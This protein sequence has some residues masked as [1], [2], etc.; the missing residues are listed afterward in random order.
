[1][2][3]SGSGSET[4]EKKTAL[5]SMDIDDTFIASARLEPEVLWIAGEA[6]KFIWLA[7]YDLFVLYGAKNNIEFH[8]AFITHRKFFDPVI[9]AA[10]DTFKNFLDLNHGHSHGIDEADR[11]KY[12]V[13]VQAKPG[14]LEY[15]RQWLDGE[16]KNRNYWVTKNLDGIHS[17]S[18]ADL[19]SNVIIF[20][21]YPEYPEY[22]GFKSKA[23]AILSIADR[24]EIAVKNC[25]HI[26]DSSYILEHIQR[27]GMQAISAE[28]FF[29][30]SDDLAIKTPIAVKR[31]EDKKRKY[32]QA[33]QEIQWKL[34]K[35]LEI[36]IVDPV[37]KTAV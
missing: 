13:S 22:K 27:S 28:C 16:G 33:I 15:P 34:V 6:G 31:A 25:H 1:M 37:F 3:G 24:Y 20:R 36:N 35:S 7:L 5:I 32:L 26:D 9:Q 29:I 30:S 19:P 4:P 10:I 2:S 12:L 18:R 11:N 23:D 8:F 17:Y 21:N 14:E